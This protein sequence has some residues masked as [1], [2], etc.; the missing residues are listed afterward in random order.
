MHSFLSTIWS[1][2]D[3]MSLFDV[4]PALCLR[5]PKPAAETETEGEGEEGRQTGWKEME[6]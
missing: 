4:S 2:F 1:A 6:N 3:L 5:Y